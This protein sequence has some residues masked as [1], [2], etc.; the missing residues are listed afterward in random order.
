MMWK[1]ICYLNNNVDISHQDHWCSYLKFRL[2]S[3]LLKG[4]GGGWVVIAMWFLHSQPH[5]CSS[6]PT[7]TGQRLSRRRSRG[8][9]PV[10]SRRPLERETPQPR[11]PL[12]SA[13]VRCLWVWLCWWM[14]YRVQLVLS[15]LACSDDLNFF[16]WNLPWWLLSFLTL[17]TGHVNKYQ[18]QSGVCWADV[19]FNLFTSHR[20]EHCH[21]PGGEQ[22]GP[23]RHHCPRCGPNW[24][25]IVTVL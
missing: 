20:C 17:S 15:N 22:E 19:K 7:S 23:A 6:W 16:T 12:S 9:W 24:G 13:Q 5:S 1:N 14:W 18:S 3:W 21:L 25:K 10:L 4:T 8:C 2:G 11:G